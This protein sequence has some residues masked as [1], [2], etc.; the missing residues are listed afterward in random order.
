MSKHVF[1]EVD[2]DDKISDDA[3]CNNDGH[4]YGI[5][6]K[7]LKVTKNISKMKIVSV[8]DSIALNSWMEDN[9]IDS[10]PVFDSLNIIPA[11]HNSAAIFPR[12]VECCVPWLW[13]KCQG[14]TIRD[15]LNM[16]IRCFDLRLKLIRDENGNRYQ[17]VHY[18]ES[19]YTFSDVMLEINDFLDINNGE[20][21]FVMIK[22]DWNTRKNWRFSDLDD[23]WNYI[24]NR[25][26]VLKLDDEMNQTNIKNVKL[27]ELRF[28]DVRGKIIMMP[29]G[30]IYDSYNNT[31]KN[32]KH[33]VNRGRDIDVIHGVKIMYPNFL[34]RCENWN[35][36]GVRHTKQRIESFLTMEKQRASSVERRMEGDE[37]KMYPLI[38]TNVVLF[39]GTIPPY[40]VSK[41]MHP[42]LKSECSQSEC[43]T[44]KGMCYV[45]RMG[46]ALLDF[47]NESLVR[48][49]LSNNWCKYY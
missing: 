26:K 36:H 8:D 34:N 10:V 29:N 20:T 45:N 11:T 25:D 19:T 32:S 43:I 18:F 2:L 12:K 28:A 48:K 1:E 3:S 13:A 35:S 22:P 15:Q 40:L 49:L 21:V 39:K 31:S 6:G 33:K 42:Y 5:E 17:I 38:E 4:V 30:H 24:K 23:L 47:A 46:F 41:C 37:S 27:H 44:D 16:G 14:Y 9:Y 7:S